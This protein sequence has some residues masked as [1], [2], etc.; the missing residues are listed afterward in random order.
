MSGE[1]ITMVQA[2]NRALDEEMTRDPSVMLLGEDVGVDGGVFR[3]TQGLLAKYGND[4]V[5]D[6]PLAESAIAGV[7]VG[8]AIGGMRPV[9]EI[10]FS[11][12]MNY[13]FEQIQPHSSR[14][15]QRT[16]G[17]LTVPMVVRAPSGG[18]IRAL[19]H[20]SESEEVMYVHTP[21]LITLMPSGPRT[22]Y[23]LMKA[24]LRAKDTVIFFEPKYVYRAIKEE[25]P[26]NGDP[27]PIGKAEIA[28]AGTDVTIVTWGAMVKRSKEAVKGLPVSVEIVDLLSLNPMD[29]DAIVASVRKTGRLVVV[30]EAPRTGGLAGEIYARVCED[31]F[32]HLRAPM[33]RVCGWDTPFPLLAREA[34]YLPDTNRIAAAVT[35]VMRD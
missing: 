12:F 4:R 14:F 24:A 7:A 6:T 8:L 1:R 35:K 23:G 29:H 27:L 30:H 21:G 16:C 28:Q 9:C 15:R 10:Q 3:V 18:G 22:A 20:H 34:A 33:M 13:A 17:S 25:V 11:G 2:I 32:Y 26:V 19:E 5:I 31:A